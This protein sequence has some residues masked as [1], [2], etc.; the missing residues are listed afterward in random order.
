VST[1]RRRELG[2]GRRSE[3][4]RLRLPGYGGFDLAILCGWRAD[5]WPEETGD[6][7]NH[8]AWMETKQRSI[9]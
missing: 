9:E 8:D 7:R 5:G 4:R 2:R 3:Q 1:W 6:A